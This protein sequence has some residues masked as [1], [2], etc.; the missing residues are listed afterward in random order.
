MT[1]ETPE[2]LW[3]RLR[4]ALLARGQL[5]PGNPTPGEIALHADRLRGDADVSRFVNE[6]YYPRLYG[7]DTGTI[8]DAE[9]GTIVAAFEPQETPRGPE[10][11]GAREPLVVPPPAAG[12]SRAAKAAIVVCLAAGLLVAVLFWVLGVWV[13]RDRDAIDLTG[14][15]F[16]IGMI[17]DVGRVQASAL[18]LTERDVAQARFT[19]D[20]GETKLSLTF[21][22]EGGTRMGMLTTPNVGRLMAIAVGDVVVYTARIDSVVTADAQLTFQSRAAASQLVEMLR[23]ATAPVAAPASEKAPGPPI[24]STD[25]ATTPALDPD[26]AALRK[27]VGEWVLVIPQDTIDKARKDGTA[28]PH[29]TLTVAADGTFVIEYFLPELHKAVGIARMEGNALA[30]VAETLDG[31]P[32]ETDEDKKPQVF[33]LSDDGSTLTAENKQAVFKKKS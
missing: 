21:T 28:E 1:P 33:T 19:A 22:P 17:D 25:P 12:W 26:L 7:D 30:L 10:P 32:P 6:Y 9:A 23:G 31:K 8:S 2:A 5:A 4:A 20:T 29:G 16:T 27:A 15:H 24:P 11:S 13:P 14:A 18:N 3:N